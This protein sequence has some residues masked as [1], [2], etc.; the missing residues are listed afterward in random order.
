MK[1]EKETV[2]G[3]IARCQGGNESFIQPQFLVSYHAQALLAL[4]SKFMRMALLAHQYSNA[5][6]PL[7]ETKD[8]I[9]KVNN[10]C[11][12]YTKYDLSRRIVLRVRVG[13]QI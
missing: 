9:P 7:Q 4:W 11:G 8:S 13:V 3:V 10:G 2:W 6:A 5:V 12:L 1:R